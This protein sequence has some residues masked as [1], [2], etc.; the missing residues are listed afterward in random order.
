[1]WQYIGMLGTILFIVCSS[2]KIN[3]RNEIE[4]SAGDFVVTAEG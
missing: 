1:M 3:V 4:G 2:S